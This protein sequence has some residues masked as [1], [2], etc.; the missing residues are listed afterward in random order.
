MRLFDLRKKLKLDFVRRG[1][2]TADVDFI[3]AE[4]LG[5]SHTELVLIDEVSSQDLDKI[6]HCVVKRLAGFPVNKIFERGYFYGREFKINQHVLAPRQDSE[7][8]IEAAIELIRKH[9]F[10]SCLDM[11]T[12]SGCLAVTLKAET[13]INMVASDISSKALA[14]AK[15]NAKL[16]NADITFIK[17]DMFEK[18]D[19][20]YD[21]IVSNPPYIASEDIAD[22][23][24]EVRDHDPLLALDGGAFGL[25]FYNIIHDNLRKHLNP[26]GMCVLE[27]G[28][29][30][31]M[32]VTALFNDF[33]LVASLQDMS[34]NDRVLV[35]KR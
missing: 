27:I 8:L 23:D 19:G 13:G 20:T 30:Q 15:Q 28:E 32:L 34:G 21:I 4:V 16:H 11:C 7:V 29:D 6:M 9:G 33:E 31:R 12:G 18:I 25:K 26:N 10:T 3:I 35:F 1:K 24:E 2:E 22:L 14:V 5:V 17:S